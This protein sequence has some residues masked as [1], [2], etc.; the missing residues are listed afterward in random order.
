M[1]DYQWFYDLLPSSMAVCQRYRLAL[2][3]MMVLMLGPEAKLGAG[4]CAARSSALRPSSLEY[5]KQQREGEKN[6]R[7]T[8][9][10]RYFHRR[11]IS[12]AEN[13]KRECSKDYRRWSRVG[14]V[15]RSVVT[16]DKIIQSN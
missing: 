10:N 11:R 7:G 4:P 3:G 2:D 13:H 14:H 5:V 8:R 12:A 9:E 16:P 1:D 15:R 6:E